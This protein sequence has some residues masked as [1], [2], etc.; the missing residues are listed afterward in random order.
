VSRRGLSA[1]R[2]PLVSVLLASALTLILVGR[3]GGPQAAGE[4]AL[5]S[6]ARAALV[7]IESAGAA[8]FRP[9][10]G[11]VGAIGGAGDLA[12][13]QS[14][15]ARQGERARSEAAR[16]EALA[17]ENARL[18]AL[19]TLDGPAADDGVAARVV[20]VGSDLAGGTLMLDRGRADGIR[21]GMPVVAAGGLV[22]RVADVG[23]RQSTVLPLTDAASAVGVRCSPAP[24]PP[25]VGGAAGVAQG[26]GGPT[27]RLDLLDPNA[28]VESDALAVTSG[29]RHSRFPA[30]LPVGRV[31]GSRGHFVV[32]PF[33]PPDRLELV[34]VLRWD[35]EP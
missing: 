31:S 32:H 14:N 35:P 30:G 4:G 7:P 21:A 34:K 9:L 1:V 28:V 8:A 20:S 22:G 18:A 5:R 26:V 24:P 3:S 16:A 2:P 27:L 19:L 12:R 6:L 25:G 15:A 23:P 33:A 13:S 29:L 10:E 11:A 17:A